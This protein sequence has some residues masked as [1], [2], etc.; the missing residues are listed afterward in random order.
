M[1]ECLPPACEG[2]A[3]GN[4][5]PGPKPAGGK[6]LPKRLPRPGL[7]RM[8]PT[9]VLGPNPRAESTHVPGHVPGR[10]PV[11]GPTDGSGPAADPTAAEAHFGYNN[12]YPESGVG[13]LT[14]SWTAG[15][16]MG[17]G[18]FGRCGDR[19]HCGSRSMRRWWN[20]LSQAGSVRASTW[21][22]PILRASLG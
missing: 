22:R 14:W 21:W 2:D 4:P 12:L 10:T 8:G 18:R 19:C 6:W 15:K 11:P 5:F 17:L 16:P 13:R 20:W 7:A 3:G 9:P 1:G